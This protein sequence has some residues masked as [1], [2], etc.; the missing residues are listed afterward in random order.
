MFC[1][2]GASGRNGGRSI[3][4]LVSYIQSVSGNEAVSIGV[5]CERQP[6]WPCPSSAMPD[7]PSL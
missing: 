5:D 4:G 3:E 6:Y 2:A 1:T 7:T